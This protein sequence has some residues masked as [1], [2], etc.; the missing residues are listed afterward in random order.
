MI[1]SDLVRVILQGG[2]SV[3]ALLLLLVY[4]LKNGTLVWGEQHRAELARERERFAARDAEADEWQ[5]IAL[6]VLGVAE[7]ITASKGG[8]RD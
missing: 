7:R 6:D 5:N 8:G 1:E 4:W 2:V 3:I